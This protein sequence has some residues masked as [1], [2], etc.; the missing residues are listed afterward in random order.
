MVT[1]HIHALKLAQAVTT[2][3][4]THP[5]TPNWSLFPVPGTDS[6]LS[7]IETTESPGQSIDQEAEVSLSN[8][9]YSHIKYKFIKKQL[10][11]LFHSQESY[12]YLRYCI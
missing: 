8:T 12:I 10:L 7:E 5:V 2:S 9:I 3:T 11:A 1:P 4:P 6:P